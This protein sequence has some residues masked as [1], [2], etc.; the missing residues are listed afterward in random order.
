MKNKQK[1]ASAGKTLVALIGAL[2]ACVLLF[3]DLISKVW[4]ESAAG[5]HTDVAL[6]GYF[7][8]LVRLYFTHNP[9]IAYGLFGGN[10]TAM[11]VVTALTVVMI[12]AIGAV[13]FT[14]F[15][16]NTPVRIVLAVIEAGAVG[17]LLD[18]LILGYV[19][20]FIDL[21]KIGFGIAN[22][23]DF[24]IVL[25]A[26]AL[27]FILLFIGEDALLPLKK[28]WREKAKEKDALKAK[29]KEDGN[30]GKSL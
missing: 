14:V 25:G 8:N 24:Y 13:Y 23:A 26:V 19:R 16:Q 18:R 28:E 22:L 21:S 17:N 15:R 2:I 12:L 10:D 29:A 20:D 9:G 7:L 11:V 5:G 3:I 1:K 27:V 6:T 4:A 30:D